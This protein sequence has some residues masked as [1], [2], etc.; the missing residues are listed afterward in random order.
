LGSRDEAIAHSRDMLRLNPNDNQG[1][2]Y[3]LAAWYAEL[4]HDADLERLLREYR[5]E[6]SAFWLWTAALLGF[7]QAGD[8]KK[9]QKLLKK[10]AGDN[11]HVAAYLLGDKAMPKSLPQF[12]SPG[13][14]SEAICY[15]NE[16]SEAWRKTD[17]ALPWLRQQGV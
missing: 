4:A 6:A 14:E 10:A 15:V 5:E 7:R 17:G 2:R 8:S 9:S 11:P 1:V 12:Y 13:E 16:F 3:V